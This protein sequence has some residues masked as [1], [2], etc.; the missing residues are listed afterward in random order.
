MT[1]LFLDF[2]S[3]SE[4]D[5]YACGLDKYLRH[6]ST[7]AVML[8]WAVDDGQVGLWQPHLDGPFCTE[9]DDALRDP[10][11]KKIAFNAPFEHGIFQ[12]PLN[13]EIPYSEW[14]DVLVLARHLSVTGNLEEVGKIFGLDEDEAKIKDGQRLITKFS[15]PT[16]KGGRE[17][18]F[19]IEP[20][21]FADWDSDPRDWELFCQYCK[22]DVTSE[23]LLYRKMQKFP[24]PET[25]VRGWLLDQKINARGI[26]ID[27]DLVG[28]GAEVAETIKEQHFT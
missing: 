3:R 6:P 22:R 14:T 25:E 20:P 27:V 7:S 19:G 28:G 8:G 12:Y 18:L 10:H 15:A 1:E 9:L 2:E 21:W 13:R 4:A 26:P 17:T 11:V 23:R 5:L 24:L 16:I